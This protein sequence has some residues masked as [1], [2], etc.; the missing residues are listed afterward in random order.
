MIP[1]PRDLWPDTKRT[2]WIY[3]CTSLA[4]GLIGALLHGA[5]LRREA[6]VAIV[7]V[8]VVPAHYAFWLFR[9]RTG[10]STAPTQPPTDPAPP[11]ARVAG[12]GRR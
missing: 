12:A 11:R 3:L 4:L 10:G 7:L 5:G 1:T 9:G 6:I 8:L 2:F